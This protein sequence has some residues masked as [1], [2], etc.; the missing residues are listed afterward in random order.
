[1]NNSLAL[2]LKWQFWIANILQATT[3]VAAIAAVIVRFTLS[4]EVA[5]EATWYA[6]VF[7]APTVPIVF[8]TLGVSRRFLWALASAAVLAIAVATLQFVSHSDRPI[9]ESLCIG[10]F[11]VLALALSIVRIA[12]YRLVL[13]SSVVVVDLTFNQA[14]KPSPNKAQPAG[15]GTATGSRGCVAFAEA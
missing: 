1:M 4:G 7:A 6:T 11:I 8:A 5:W 13:A 14:P 9:L 12:G 15:S 10:Q 2:P 3:L